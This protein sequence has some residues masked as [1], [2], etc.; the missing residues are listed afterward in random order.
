MNNKAYLYFNDD[1]I[2][3]HLLL[4]L[5]FSNMAFFYH[6]S[7]VVV[8]TPLSS[9]ADVLG[10]DAS[11]QGDD[12][13][14]VRFLRHRPGL[15]DL[16]QNPKTIPKPGLFKVPVRNNSGNKQVLGAEF[17]QHYSG[18][19]IREAETVHVPSICS[20]TEIKQHN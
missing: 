15:E 20:K 17:V 3:L 4:I 19:L 9:G 12:C 14:Q 7:F 5:H 13:G 16:L 6:T 1:V 11:P 18:Q 10:G 8:V 2:A